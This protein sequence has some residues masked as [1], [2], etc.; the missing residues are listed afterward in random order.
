MNRFDRL[1]NASG[2]VGSVLL[3]AMMMWMMCRPS[4]PSATRPDPTPTRPTPADPP[5]IPP[6]PPPPVSKVDPVAA[7]VRL[8][9]GNAGCTATVLA[10]RPG[11]GRYYVLSAAHCVRGAKQGTVTLSNGQSFTVRVLRTNERADLALLE[12]EGPDGL[13][14]AEVADSVP[15]IGTAVWHQ[16]FGVDRPGNRETGTVSGAPGKDG[17]IPLSLSVSSGDSGSGIFRQDN[18]QLVSVV[19][20]TGN[21][22]TWGGTVAAIR[23]LIGGKDSAE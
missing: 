18:G 23:G 13:P 9:M 12:M 8:R 5:P 1:M 17:Q 22:T 6:P 7:T 19:C 4:P 20:C 3:L 16:G 21:G 10:T 15:A 2:P 14:T 11:P